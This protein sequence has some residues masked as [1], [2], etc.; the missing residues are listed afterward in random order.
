MAHELTQR[1]DGTAEMAY[2]GDVPWHGLGQRLTPGASIEE[3][4]QAAGMDWMIGRRALTYAADRACTDLRTLTDQQ[5]LIRLDSGAPLGIVSPKYNIVQPGEVL[6]FFRTLTA[7]AGFQLETA[8]TLFGGARYWA[9]AKVTEATLAGWDRVGG[10]CLISTTADGSRATEVRKTTVRVVCNNTLG[11]ALAAD[12]KDVI[13]IGHR[14]MFS[15]EKVHEKMGLTV[16]Q[17]DT[18]IEAA[19]TLTKVKVTT[20]AAEDFVARLLRAQA[21]KAA[22]QG[23]DED[24][25]ALDE[26]AKSRAPRGLEMILGLFDGAGRGADQKGSK[27]TAWGLVNAVTEYV[28]HL[29]TAKTIDH[30]LDRAF[31][32]SGDKLKTLAL[33]RA[34]TQL[35]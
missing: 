29:A 26:D 32:G 15:I 30:R 11:M 8:G 14:E 18:F 23:D 4:K 16:E 19:N 1:H 28:D 17:F 12:T 6:E 20:A 7:E 5:L 33:Q 25:D 9:L 34:L 31:F 35:A 21:G 27:G 10:Y 24:A 13:R 3:W 22:D 2:V